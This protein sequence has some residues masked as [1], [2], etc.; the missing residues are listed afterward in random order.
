M[1]LNLRTV[2]V[3]QQ[4]KSQKSK[5]RGHLFQKLSLRYTDI[6]PTALAGPLKCW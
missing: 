3:Y 5:V 1:T 6:G 2:K 4:A